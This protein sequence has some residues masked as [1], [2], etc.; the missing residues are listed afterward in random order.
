MI[1]RECIVGCKTIEGNKVVAKNRDRT[2][3]ADAFVLHYVTNGLEYA[4]IFDPKTKYMEGLNATTGIAIMN[5]ALMNGSDFAAAES[6]EGMYI[7]AAL[8]KA[9][10]PLQAAKMLARDN[11]GVY[12]STIIA[13]EEEVLVLENVP[14]SP[15][16]CVRKNVDKFPVVR[17]NHS[18][19]IPHV[20][21]TAQD[22]DDYISSKTRQAVG[23]VM[24]ASAE[25]AESLLD[26]LNYSVF[27]HHSAFDTT[28][29]TSGM[30][31]CSQMAIDLKEKNLYFRAIPGHGNLLG[32]HRFGD[33]DMSPEIKV[34]ILDYNEP[35]QVPFESW[36]SS[37]S[38]LPES[39]D[40]ARLLD[41]NDRYDD[42]T[43]LNDVEAAAIEDRTEEDNVQHYVDRENEI[44]GMLVSL[45]NLMK[46][47]DAGMQHLLK[48]RDTTED[49][50]YIDNM[51]RDAEQ[52]T[53]DLYNLKS[54]LRG[55]SIGES[56]LRKY[57]RKLIIETRKKINE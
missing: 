10:T 12:G 31:T 36:G 49:E 9:K 48:N 24:F 20:G 19:E 3:D 29:E 39:F 1:L 4:V 38:N 50:T 57:I 27:G 17:T 40:L 56:S 14:D 15:S 35:A 6:K 54:A 26:A 28:R 44:I 5:V 42:T 55:K 2:Y 7:M 33:K 30:R 46:N 45:Q 47:D 8:L 18:E 23:E 52:S 16:K 22:G 37:M 41:P 25:T 43:S 51:L 21:Y 34:H 53:M 32:V 13:N 11:Q